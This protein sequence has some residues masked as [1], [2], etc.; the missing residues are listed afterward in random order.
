MTTPTHRP[1]SHDLIVRGHLRDTGRV[2]P[3]E[4]TTPDLVELTRRVYDAADGGDFDPMMR[5]FRP[6]AVWE[7][8]E[9]IE[10]LEDAAA[11]R[12]FVEDWQSSYEEYEVE[13]EEIVD[14]GN[15][16]TFAV[17]VQRGRLVGSSADTRIR[18][19]VIYTW[20]DGLIVRMLSHGDVEKGRAIAERLAESRG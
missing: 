5:L 20:A 11:I 7:Q 16:V 9:G 1:A 17:S 13:V 4:S 8:P 6:D 18:F 10:T 19:P 15:G 2:M 14:F 12:R 3:E